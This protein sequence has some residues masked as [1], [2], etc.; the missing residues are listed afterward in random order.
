M[1]ESLSEVF[2]VKNL[3]I[4]VGK[5]HW[6]MLAFILLFQVSFIEAFGLSPTFT[7]QEVSD[8]ED[9]ILF[10]SKSKT[11]E[12]IDLEFQKIAANQS[13]SIDSVNYFSDGKNLKA[14]LWLSNFDR[15]PSYEKLYD[16]GGEFDLSYG[17]LLD[18]VS[19]NKKGSNP[20]DYDISTQCSCIPSNQTW[21][22]IYYELS[23]NGSNKRIVNTSDITHDFNIM[24]KS[25]DR[26]KFIELSADLG[27]LGFPKEYRIMYYA[28][29]SYSFN[30]EISIMDVTNLLTVPSPTILLSIMPSSIELRQGEEKVINLQ[31]NASNQFSPLVN[32]SLDNRHRDIDLKSNRD[33]LNIPSNGM[34][35]TTLTVRA[36][37][38]ASL[39]IH[40]ATLYANT[41][42]FVDPTIASYLDK[43]RINNN[44]IRIDEEKV[45]DQ[46]ILLIDVKPALELSERIK[47]AWE[48]WGQAVSGFNAL[49]I[50]IIAGLSPFLINKLRRKNKPN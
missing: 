22:K 34:D 29:Y 7:K 37:P 1:R 6:L 46:T 44:E 39:G 47:D 32:L 30:P 36:D 41:S 38:H 13:V 20:F 33:Q 24:Q 40:Y 9:N 15:F 12:D 18:I 4:Y 5:H 27:F 48:N 10:S 8:I 45:I 23:S 26:E 28:M 17:I 50:A 31:V 16:I 14:I 19:N 25:E 2:T 3:G 35:G 11:I 21:K 49:I 42:F 43:V